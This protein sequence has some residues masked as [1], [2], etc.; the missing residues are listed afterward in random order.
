M[1]SH[2]FQGVCWAFLAL[3]SLCGG[4]HLRHHIATVHWYFV[5]IFARL[6]FQVFRNNERLC[7]KSTHLIFRFVYGPVAM[8][9]DL[10]SVHCLFLFRQ[11][12]CVGALGYIYVPSIS[13]V[14]FWGITSLFEEKIHIDS[15]IFNESTPFDN[16]EAICEW[17]FDFRSRV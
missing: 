8:D 17:F 7:C 12:S 1:F 15:V 2:L 9:G 16:V 6:L 13:E 4:P 5:G 10:V 14:R 11:F 3:R